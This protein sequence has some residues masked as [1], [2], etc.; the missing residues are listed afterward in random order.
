MLIDVLNVERLEGFSELLQYV[1]P[2]PLAYKVY[3]EEIAAFAGV[4]KFIPRNST[5]SSACV[6]V[7]A[8]LRTVGKTFLLFYPADPRVLATT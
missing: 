2:F 8:I 6:V 7:N 4:L 5:L 3:C 1:R